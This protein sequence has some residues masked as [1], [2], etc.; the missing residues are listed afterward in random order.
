MLSSLD[1]LVRS[2]NRN[3]LGLFEIEDVTDRLFRN[4]GN[5]SLIYAV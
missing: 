5:E 2:P 1:W 3:L 4:I